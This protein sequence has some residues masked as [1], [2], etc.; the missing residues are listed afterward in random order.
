MTGGET[1]HWL[2]NPDT[3]NASS[4]AS[5]SPARLTQLPT[6]PL[7]NGGFGYASFGASFH[8]H[9]IYEIGTRE[10]GSPE[11]VLYET[12][13]GQRVIIYQGHHGDATNFDPLF[14]FDDPSG[15]WFTD[16]SGNLWRWEPGGTLKKAMV[17]G[18][19]G[20]LPGPNSGRYISPA[21]TCGG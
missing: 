9:P 8:G 12:A 14:G 3:G 7:Q 2:I 19:P 1:G 20:L 4:E 15:M 10:Q 21:G 17:T 6:D 11:I 13:P 18:L 16:Y 5:Q